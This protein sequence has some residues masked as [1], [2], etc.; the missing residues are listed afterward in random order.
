MKIEP[1]L[2]HIKNFAKLAHTILCLPSGHKCSGRLDLASKHLA[3]VGRIYGEGDVGLGLWLAGSTRASTVLQVQVPFGF[4]VYIKMLQ[5]K[6]KA[7][8]QHKG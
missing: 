4:I 6:Y 7:G 8:L 1:K 5:P 2:E 3:E